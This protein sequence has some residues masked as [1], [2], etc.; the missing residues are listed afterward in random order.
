MD[1]LFYNSLITI[2]GVSICSGF[3]GPFIL[4]K[5]LNFFGDTIAH[6]ALLG[7]I[8]S[9]MLKVHHIVGILLVSLFPCFILTNSPK[10]YSKD[11]LLNVI[12]NTH[13]SLAVIMLSALSLPTSKILSILFGDLLSVNQQDIILIYCAAIVIVIVTFVQR[14]KWLLITI[15]EDLALVNKLPVKSLQLTF[16]LF[17]SVFIAISINILGVLLV[18]SLLIIPAAIA[19]KFISTPIQMML[20]SCII[21]FFTSTFGLI[22]SFY[23]DTPTSATIILT[24]AFFLFLSYIYKYK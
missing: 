11:M 12:S 22:L 9:T 21:C 3:I 10:H 13:F 15:S 24:A 19:R 17:L 16:M 1:S 23:F 4:W 14:Q 5:R 18:T 7:V 8:I 2:L 20:L 6:S